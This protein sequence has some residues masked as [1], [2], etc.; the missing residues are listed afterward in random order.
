MSQ[1]QEVDRV[2]GD[3]AE[4][5]HHTA[6]LLEALAC[7]ERRREMSAGR[8]Q[9]PREQGSKPGRAGPM[10]LFDCVLRVCSADYRLNA[11]IACPF[12]R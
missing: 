5:Q 4:A 2:V 8:W 7:R 3:E 10:G 1:Q 9:R 6:P 11:G 12:H